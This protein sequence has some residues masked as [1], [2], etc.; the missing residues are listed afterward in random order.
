M[1]VNGQMDNLWHIGT[2]YLTTKKN[3]LLTE[4]ITWMDLKGTMLSLRSQFPKLHAVGSNLDPIPE[5]T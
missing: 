2:E 4:A 3:K 1:S 5:I